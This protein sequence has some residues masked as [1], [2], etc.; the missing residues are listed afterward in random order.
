M[1]KQNKKVKRE[2]KRDRR[3]STKDTHTKVIWRCRGEFQFF[4]LGFF[5]LLLGEEITTPTCVDVWT[6]RE[7]YMCLRLIHSRLLSLRVN[8]STTNEKRKIRNKRKNQGEIEATGRWGISWRSSAR[9]DKTTSLS[10]F[11]TIVSFLFFYL[12]LIAETRRRTTHKTHCVNK[13][14]SVS[15]DKQP[16]ASSNKTE[17]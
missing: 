1:G 3:R 10:W 11:V 17:D 7:F 8:S 5:F 13:S 15:L 12:L 2:K 9:N 4:F 16:S 14:S 6:A